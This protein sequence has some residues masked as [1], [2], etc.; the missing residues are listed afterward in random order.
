[1][2]RSVRTPEIV[3]RYP[4]VLSVIFAAFMIAAIAA[5]QVS[6]PFGVVIGVLGGVFLVWRWVL[7]AQR[8]RARR[9]SAGS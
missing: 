7:A 1:M 3:R 4:I 5:A 6:V 8:G 9:E 2:H